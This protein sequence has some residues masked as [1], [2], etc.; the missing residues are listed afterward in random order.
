M[1]QVTSALYEDPKL[2]PDFK[3][4]EQE[5]I[6]LLK[7][8]RDNLGSTRQEVEQA[9]RNAL[10]FVRGQDPTKSADYRSRLERSKTDS[11]VEEG[12]AEVEQPLTAEQKLREGIF[13]HRKTTPADG[14]F[15]G[16]GGQ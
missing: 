16:F 12:S 15:A 6:E 9:F 2:G 8:H 11:Q 10:I 14:L 4:Y 13:N 7:P 3:A 5:I 1:R